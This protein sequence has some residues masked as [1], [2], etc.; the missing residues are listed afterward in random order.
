MTEHHLDTP[1][2]HWNAIE[3][4][5]KKFEIRK[6]D[7]GLQ[8]GDIIH[9]YCCSDEDTDSFGCISCTYENEYGCCV[10][11]RDKAKVLT[12]KVG[13]I[14]TGG[15]HGIEPGYIVFSLEKF[16]DHKSDCAV[17]NAPAYESGECDCGAVA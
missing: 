8:L 11:D 17:N 14:M 3:A 5:L 4:G 15:Q 13:W 7:G 2:S 10:E 6:D 1:K 9:L 12:F 16:Q